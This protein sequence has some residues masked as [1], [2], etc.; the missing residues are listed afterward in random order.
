MNFPLVTSKGLNFETFKEAA[1]IVAR[2]EHLNYNGLDK[3]LSLKETM[4]KGRSFDE[5]FNYLNS[6]EIKLDPSWVQAFVDAEGCF[7]TLITKS[8]KTT[9]KIVTRN[10]LSISQS[11]HDFPVLKAIK[12][13]FN[14]G[15]TSPKAEDMNCLDKAKLHSDKSFYYNSMPET[16]IPFFDKYP[17][18]TR[19]QLD[20][21]DFKGFYLLKENKAY[22]S[23]AGFE[24]M[25]N[26]CNN[27]NSGRDSPDKKRKY[28]RPVN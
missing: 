16:I 2:G 18:Y 9:G 8:D 23:N 11:S 22:L 27:M 1:E 7:G 25:R 15:Y 26:I 10:R 3:I 5:L 24:E 20:Y 14:K 28:R 21:L 4:N 19:K 6:K 13:F 12:D 17:M